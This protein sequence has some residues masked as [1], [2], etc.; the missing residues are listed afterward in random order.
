MKKIAALVLALVLVL[1]LAMVSA[2]CMVEINSTFGEVIS[3]A[4]FCSYIVFAGMA[5]EAIRF[6]CECIRDRRNAKR[7]A[8]ERAEEKAKTK[9]F[10][11]FYEE[12]CAAEAEEAK[13]QEALSQFIVRPAA[14]EEEKTDYIDYNDVIDFDYIKEK[15]YGMGE[16]LVA[17]VN[18]AD[19]LPDLE[20][21]HEME[22]YEKVFDILKVDKLVTRSYAA[23][24]HNHNH[25]Y[26]EE[27]EEEDC[28]LP[29]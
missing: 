7:I 13:A 24:A 9:L 21:Y 12:L 19:W 16:E 20:Y 5:A 6:E 27:N 15:W 11:E 14:E 26:E 18:N 8:A 10:Y 3:L 17:N 25:E 28:E 22:A 4:C 2:I 29:F 1:S 23:A